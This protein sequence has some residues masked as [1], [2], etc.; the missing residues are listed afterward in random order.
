MYEK[1][2]TAV[3]E[4]VYSYAMDVAFQYLC[5]GNTLQVSEVCPLS[6]KLTGANEVAVK[7]HTLGG[8]SAEVMFDN[9]FL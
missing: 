1:L 2:R 7:M 6:R 9:K 8:L 4:P 3:R 5:Q